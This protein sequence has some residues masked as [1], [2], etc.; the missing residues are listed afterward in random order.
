MAS[1]QEIGIG[2][3]AKE[4]NDLHD[5]AEKDLGIEPYCAICIERTLPNGEREILYRYDMPR[6]IMWD[7]RW[8]YEW[9]K[10][11]FVCKYPKDNVSMFFS[12]YDKG[13]G[14]EY[15]YNS[16]RSRQVAAKALI[17][18]YKNRREA[19]IEHAKNSLFFDADSDD[20]LHALDEKISA[21]ECRYAELTNQV[22]E[23]LKEK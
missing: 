13:T 17:S 19:Y 23:L 8:V 7:Y 5:K 4:Y 12:F 1:K 16:L 15:E 11:R 14:L 22:E 21:A 3:E 6:K 9:R 10:A 2:A 20:T 18:K